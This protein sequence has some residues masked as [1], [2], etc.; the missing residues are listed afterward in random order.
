MWVPAGEHGEEL[1][2]HAGDYGDDFDASTP[3]VNVWNSSQAHLGV[4]AVGLTRPRERRDPALRVAVAKAHQQRD[5]LRRD[6]P[7][8]ILKANGRVDE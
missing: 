5:L 6:E 4:V 2:D 3:T 8:H 7:M 1:Y